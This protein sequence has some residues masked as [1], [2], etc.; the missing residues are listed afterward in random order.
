MTSRFGTITT[1]MFTRHNVCTSVRLS[2]RGEGAPMEIQEA[3]EIVR[4]LADDV[5]L[6]TRQSTGGDSLYRNPQAVRALNRA[7]Q[8]LEFQQE[9][10]RTRK[11]L[12]PNAGKAWSNAED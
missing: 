3:L 2:I 9:R 8:A 7:V 10:E 6:E 4:K 11:S 12:P 5:H 1:F